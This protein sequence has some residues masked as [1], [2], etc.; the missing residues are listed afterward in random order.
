MPAQDVVTFLSK[1]VPWYPFRS[2]TSGRSQRHGFQ[3]KAL[4]ADWFS[5]GL[6]HPAPW[7]GHKLS[8]ALRPPLGFQGAQ[9]EAS[10]CCVLAW[11]PAAPGPC[12][13]GRDVPWT[14]G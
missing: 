12:W 1:G 13:V 4:G 5:E 10:V 3:G 9:Q 7:L 8:W 11:A 14:L 2:P 6:T